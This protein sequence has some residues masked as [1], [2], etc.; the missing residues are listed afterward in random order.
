MAA[1]VHNP[2]TLAAPLGLYS[3]VAEARG[4]RTVT[5]AGQVGADASGALA[6][7]DVG[8]QTRRAYENLGLA[9]ASAG[10]TWRDVVKMTTFLVSEELIEPF[11]AA[12]REVFAELFPD[13]AYPTNTLLVVSRL[14]HAEFL[15][16]I[17]AT[18][19]TD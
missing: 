15:V 11:M 19:V 18:A 7:H 6:G 13:A 16:E 5:I 9:L 8:A 4:A 14:V 3:H 2:D 12:R 1:S 10:A 17:E